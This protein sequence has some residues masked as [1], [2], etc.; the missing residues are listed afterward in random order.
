MKSPILIIIFFLSTQLCAQKKVNY[1]QQLSIKELTD[2]LNLLRTELEEKHPALYYYTDKESMD[3]IFQSIEQSIQ[4]E[5]SVLEFFRKIQ[6]LNGHIKDA[7]TVI[8]TPSS[9]INSL[10]SELK[11]FPFRT[12]TDNN[13]IY[14]LENYVANSE[15]VLGSEILEINETPIREIVDQ[16]SKAMHR[17]GHNQTY[18]TY[19]LDKY[20]ALFYAIQIGCPEV[21]TIK[22]Q[23]PEGTINTINVDALPYEDMLAQGLEKRIK[24]L[25]SIPTYREEIVDQSMIL[26]LQSFT[27]EYIKKATGKGYKKLFKEAFQKIHDQ[28]IQRLVIDIRNNPGGW[29][30]VA[31]EFLSHLIPYKFT[32]DKLDKARIN[33]IE[34]KPYYVQNEYIKHFNRQRFKEKKDGFHEVKF[35]IKSKKPKS[36]IFK[37][38]IIVLIN[39]ACGSQSGAFAGLIEEHLDATFIGEETGANKKIM[40][41]GDVLTVELPNSQIRANIPLR[42]IEINTQAINNGHGVKPDIQLRPSITEKMKGD[43][44]VLERALEVKLKR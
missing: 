2:D 10:T 9:Y 26:S 44:V 12:Y 39:A 13:K 23:E 4:E 14:I 3:D 7:H 25:E 41:G 30:E 20:F 15:I 36:K 5:Q 16:L 29:P 1:D 34:N 37:G 17:D 38:E 40:C 28:K 18:L 21:Y 33:K 22:I 27:P 42:Q 19:L 24:E 43:D 35:L 32:H 31:D 8:F 6:F 11:R